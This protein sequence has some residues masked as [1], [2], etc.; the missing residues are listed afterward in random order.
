MCSISKLKELF[1]FCMDKGCNMPI[2]EV[3]EK[4]VGCTLELGGVAKL[5]I[6]VIGCPVRWSTECMLII[7]TLLHP[8]YSLATVSV[9]FPYLQNLCNY[10]LSAVAH[11]STI[12]EN[13]LLPKFTT[14]GN[15]CKNVCLKSLVISLLWFLAMA[16][17]IHLGSV[18][19]I[20]HT[21][22]CMPLW[23]IFSKWRL[24]TFA[25]RS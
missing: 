21:P 22:S 10:H 12:K 11:S 2:T 24:L 25:S 23:I 1:N 9:R 14:F 19:S 16:R 5:A 3:F 13:T 20:V 15:L 4:F 6:V 18:P 7:Y 8:S 17:W